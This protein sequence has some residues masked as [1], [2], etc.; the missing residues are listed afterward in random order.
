MPQSAIMFVSMILLIGRNGLAQQIA[1]NAVGLGG[2]S[3]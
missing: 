3:Q 2:L 1:L